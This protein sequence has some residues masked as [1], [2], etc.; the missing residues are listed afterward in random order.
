LLRLDTSTLP[1]EHHVRF[2]CISDTHEK[3]GELLPLIP[4]GDV[5]IHCGDFTQY[6]DEAKIRKFNEQ[7][8]SLPHRYKVV[9]AGNHEIGF[10]VSELMLNEL[11]LSR[12]GHD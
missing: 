2:V 6:G 12:P 10:E 5:L 7:M 8:G 9:V 3:L 11:G 4:D 1:D